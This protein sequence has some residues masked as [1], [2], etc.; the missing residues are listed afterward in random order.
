MKTFLSPTLRLILTA[1]VILLAGLSALQMIAPRAVPVEAPPSRFSAERAMA[2]LK[3]V[4]REPHAAGSQAQANVRAYIVKQ[5][6]A[7]GLKAMIETSG[8]LANILV[9][10]PGSNPS[11]IVLVSGHYDSHPPAPGAG[12][13]GI[14][15]AAM[16][17]SLRVLHAGPA[18]RN[19]LMFLFTDGEEL[20]WEGAKAFIRAHPEA[21]YEVGMLLV[22]DARPGNAPL[23]LIKT[24]PGDA[25]LLQQMTGLS[26]PLWAGSWKNLQERN[27]M[28]TDYDIFQPAGY[29]GVIF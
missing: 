1:A 21:K 3:V 7:L 19:D 5:V 14:S 13:D 20:G 24:S 8:Q 27:E 15:L 29:T 2:D 23:Q 25:W 10:L 9:R 11:Q 17:E 28:D 6:E 4:A 26:L 16:L 22:F 18:L 12:D